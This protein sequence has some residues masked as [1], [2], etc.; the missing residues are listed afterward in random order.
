MMQL[1]RQVLK[2]VFVALFAIIAGNA[3]AQQQRPPAVP[4]V[5]HN[6]YFSIWSMDDKLTDSP[7]RHW[8]GTNQPLVG[9]V[10]I[11]GKAYRYMGGNPREVPAMQQ[12]SVVVNATHT[13]YVF[14][15]AGIQLNLA[16]FT[17]AFPQDIDLLSRPVTYLTWDITSTD[18]K[19]HKVELLLD[20]NGL[21]AVNTDDQKVT[22]GRSETSSLHVLN[23]GSLD[24]KVLARSGDNLRIDWGYFHLAVPKD[25]QAT[26]AISPNG[27]SDF[28]STGSLPVAD[29]MAMPRAPNADAA[30]LAVALTAD[31]MPGKTV[32]RHVL[33]SY[34]E[35]YAIEYLGRWERPYWQR[36]N[37][38]VPQMLDEAQSEYAALD[39]RGTKYDAAL[40]KDL[41]S[42]GGLGYRELA[43][44]AYRQTLAA[45]GLVAGLDGKPL[46]F[47]KENFSCG[48]IATV[49]V[50]YPSSP[51]FLFFAPAL[52]EAQMRPILEYASLPGWKNPWAPHDLGRYPLANGHGQT[53][54]DGPTSEEESMPVEESGNMLIMAAALGEAQGNLHLAREYWPLFT[55]WAEFLRE[56]GLDPENQLCTD[57]FAGKLAHNTNLSIKAIDGLGA[58]AQMARG[59][60]ETKTADEYDEAAKQMATKWEQ[61]AFDGDHYKLAFD[62]S[63]TWSQKY[64]LVWDQL[65]DLH[66]FAPKVRATEVAFYLKHLNLYGLPLDDRADYTKTDWE[67][68]TATLA[69]NPADFAALINPIV[70]WANE[71]PTR[72]PLTD[73][74]NTKTGV[75][76]GFQA[77]SVVGGIY[78]KALTDK[79]LAVKW[80]QIQ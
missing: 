47:E 29:D 15:V 55:K 12:S 69:E 9:L 34:T 52:L 43:M 14:E 71:T 25:E 10:R 30:H 54:F 17:P 75:K 20:V 70:K 18:A 19:P 1:F 6:P 60:G 35:D 62:R 33:L 13:L 57:D 51:F 40:D 23:I 27:V 11:D 42:V 5:T 49:D 38:S 41:E 21:V 56:K 37:K 59:L 39:A 48:C 3:K 45:H 46:M 61:M 8:T 66:L 77:R 16:F 67:L 78:I 79:T 32:S 58:Y 4:L 28:I 68:W 22:W 53:A 44:L 7:T 73:W 76:T 63:G 50:M 36:D 26:L 64:N 72:V 80:R 74:Y 2:I 31:V 65:L 24:Q